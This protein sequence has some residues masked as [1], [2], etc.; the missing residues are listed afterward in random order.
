MGL[1]EGCR[2][3]V[4]SLRSHVHRLRLGGGTL[5]LTLRLLRNTKRDSVRMMLYSGSTFDCE[6]ESSNGSMVGSFNCSPS[7]R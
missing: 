7:A 3:L 5:E 4:S 6:A 2:N 1:L